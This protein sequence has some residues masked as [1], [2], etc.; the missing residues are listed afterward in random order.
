MGLPVGVNDGAASTKDGYAVGMSLQMGLP[1]GD[2]V[3]AAGISGRSERFS[4]AIGLAVRAGFFL[5][6]SDGTGGVT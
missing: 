2:A 3:G 1:V 6:L 4:T 5:W